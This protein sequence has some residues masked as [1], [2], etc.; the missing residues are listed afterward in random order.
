M[1][2]ELDDEAK[3]KSAVAL[4]YSGEN[5]PTV[6]AKGHGKDAEEIIRI[7]KENDVP[8][9]DN[10]PLAQMLTQLELG[11]TI[12]KELYLAIAHIIAYAYK[13]QLRILEED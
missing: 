7:A 3:L 11:E 2:D 1:Y 9:C 4:F 5:A 12:P 6:T 10:A 8:L 13:L